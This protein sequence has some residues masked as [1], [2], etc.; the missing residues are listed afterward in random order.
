MEKVISIVLNFE[1]IADYLEFMTT[2]LSQMNETIVK[3]SEEIA[4]FQNGQ[5]NYS[6]DLKQELIKVVS[7]IEVIES[8]MDNDLTDYRDRIDKLEVR[9]SGQ[10]DSSYTGYD[11]LRTQID[12]LKS[13]IIKIERG[14]SEM[15][16]MTDLI[17]TQPKPNLASVIAQ[18]KSPLDQ[19]PKQSP[20]PAKNV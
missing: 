5:N 19:K 12:L 16:K 8:R 17:N 13:K 7:R 9:S 11:N 18:S 4:M 2:K 14:G 6:H 3:Q 15:G 10:S 1:N 20:L